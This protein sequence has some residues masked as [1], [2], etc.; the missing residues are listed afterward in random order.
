MQAHW[1]VNVSLYSSTVLHLYFLLSYNWFHKY[2]DKDY[3][4]GVYKCCN[5]DC[6]VIFRAKIKQ[7]PKS[8][9][10]VVVII[11]VCNTCKHSLI[12]RKNRYYG[13]QR[14]ELGPKLVANGIAQTMA[15]NFLS[16]IELDSTGN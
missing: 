9:E 15:E 6:D 7:K 2:H 10:D 4:Y 1:R 13:D 8:F 12:P 14:K 5:I 11:G 3:W 16:N